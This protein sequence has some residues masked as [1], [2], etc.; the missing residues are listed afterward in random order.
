MERKQQR[1]S[2]KFWASITR[3][4]SNKIFCL[5]HANTMHQ[6]KIDLF[7][8]FSQ[9]DHCM[10]IIE[11]SCMNL[12]KTNISVITFKFWKRADSDTFTWWNMHVRSSVRRRKR[13]GVCADSLTKLGEEGKGG[14]GQANRVLWERV[15]HN[16]RQ[17][18]ST[19]KRNLFAG[20]FW[21][22]NVFYSFS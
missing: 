11:K 2:A 19:R 16:W 1:V 8:Q 10:C 7:I 17:R 20:L 9:S 14:Q 22:F 18:L 4:A 6:E 21:F 12:W 15:V 13:D 5:C 3:G